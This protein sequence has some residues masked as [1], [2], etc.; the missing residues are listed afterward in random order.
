M[1]I[2]IR[3]SIINFAGTA[4]TLVAVGT[5]NEPSMLATTRA[6]TPRIGSSR[7]ASGVLK[8]GTGLTIGSAG[9]GDCSERSRTSFC[10]GEVGVA[11]TGTGVA[12]VGVAEVGVAATGAAGVTTGAALAAFGVGGTPPRGAVITGE[13]EATAELFAGLYVLK[14]SIHDGSTEVGSA[15]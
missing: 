10:V 9:V 6:L 3:L 7:A 2:T 14:N 12:E 5:V 8:T 13:L 4:R 11:A 1:L 15:K